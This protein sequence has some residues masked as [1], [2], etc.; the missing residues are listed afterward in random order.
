M[1]LDQFNMTNSRQMSWYDAAAPDVSIIVI[2]YNNSALTI[3]CLHEIWRH[4]YGKRY[5]I[6][7]V[8]NGSAA[9]DFRDLAD[10]AGEC[11]LIRLPVN[12]FFGE[13]NNIGV[14]AA[15]GRYVVFLNNDAFVTDNWLLPLI[16]VLEGQLRAGAVGPKFLYPDGRLQE[17]GAFVA[18]EKG[19]IIQRGIAYPVDA[20]DIA[21]VEIVDYCS[22]ACLAMPREVFD[23]LGGFDPAFEPAYYEDVDLCFRIASLGLFIYFCPLTTVYHIGNA[24]SKK[25][26][27]GLGLE[28]IV[29]INRQKFVARWGEHL[30]AREASGGAQPPVLEQGK[31]QRR[32]GKGER[33]RIAVFHSPYDLNPGGR[34]RYLLTAA[35]A[36][37]ESH[38]VYVATTAPYSDYRLDYMARELA[39]DLSCVSLVTLE[40]LSGIGPID[41]FVHLGDNVLPRIAGRGRR[42]VYVCQFPHPMA[43]PE[44]ADSW[45]N[46]RSYDTVLVFSQFVRNILVGRINAFQ[47]CNEIAVLEPPARIDAPIG[48]PDDAPSGRPIILSIGSFFAGL[49]NKRHDVLITGIRELVQAGVAAELHIVGSLP[50]HREDLL[51]YGALGQHSRGLPVYLHPNASQRAIRDLRATA[52]IYWHAR[53]FEADPEINPELCEFFG[54]GIVEA[55][56]AGCVPLVVA[57]G[58][59]TQFVRDKETGFQY[60]TIDELVAKTQAILQDRARAVA[61]SEQAMRE[62]GRFSE[63]TFQDKWRQLAGG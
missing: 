32:N 12:R 37:A 5:E 6:I 16:N 59:P 25:W 30:L 54:I 24:T 8:D 29:E 46:L 3:K 44:L 41:L 23:C 36:L 61:I 42:N 50:P 4:T 2:N 47:F 9:D 51:H 19:G 62:A 15:H 52:Q 28:N 49:H 34:E 20:A 13:G 38:R 33:R 17:A 10:I 63:S 18:D 27:Q 21:Q 35:Q 43:D 14:Q 31:R 48:A 60:A 26:A 40:E 56:A 45:Q 55:M 39:I 7:V 22:A 57:N 58:G 53:G 11:H 1:T